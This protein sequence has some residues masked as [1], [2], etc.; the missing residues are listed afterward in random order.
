MLLRG[1]RG[2]STRPG[3]VFYLVYS[4]LLTY[5]LLYV[6]DQK[7][8]TSYLQNMYTD[9][10]FEEMANE[11]LYY[12]SLM[13]LGA[14]SASKMLELWSC[15]MRRVFRPTP[16][17]GDL[18]ADSYLILRIHLEIIMIYVCY[19]GL[20]VYAASDLGRLEN[21]QGLNFRAIEFTYNLQRSL[22]YQVSL[23]LR[24]LLNPQ[25]YVTFAARFSSSVNCPIYFLRLT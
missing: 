9:E 3:G 5:I 19:M 7:N 23:E 1:G 6:F 13:V 15:I 8:V 24:V 22:L 10:M 11:T 21:K 25:V 20:G 12:A 18:S 17:V 2:Q 14:L 4:F 16:W